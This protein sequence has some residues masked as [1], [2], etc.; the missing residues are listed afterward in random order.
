[1]IGKGRRR[2]AAGRNSGKERENKSGME[3]NR[4]GEKR[5]RTK[6]ALEEVINSCIIKLNHFSEKN[7]NL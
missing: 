5:G 6:T 1:M 2:T 4:E 3:Q 7:T